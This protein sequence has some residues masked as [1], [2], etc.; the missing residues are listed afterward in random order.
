M[1]ELHHKVRLNRG[2]RSDLHWWA[3]FLPAWNGKSTMS[4]VVRNKSRGSLPQGQFLFIGKNGSDLCNSHG[5]LSPGAGQGAWPPVP[6]SGQSLP[7]TAEVCGRSE[8]CPGQG[9]YRVF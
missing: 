9:W 5:E 7:D 1:H 3:C 4:S 2:F 8:G 6:I